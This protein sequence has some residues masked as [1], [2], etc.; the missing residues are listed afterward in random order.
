[1]QL[2]KPNKES[3]IHATETLSPHN[4]KGDTPVVAVYGIFKE[5]SAQL[6]TH[7]MKGMHLWLLFMGWFCIEQS[8]TDQY[9]TSQF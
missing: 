9:S 2:I 5:M 1:M 6:T 7:S 3:L 8:L 4:K